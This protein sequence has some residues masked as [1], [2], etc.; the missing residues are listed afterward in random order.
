MFYWFF[1]NTKASVPLRPVILWL[2]GGP[3]ASSLGPLFESIG[4]L[5]I[6]KTGTTQDDW[7]VYAADQ[8]WADEYHLLFVD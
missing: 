7:V 6:N 5:R 2:S 3:G 1:K 4:P 8:S